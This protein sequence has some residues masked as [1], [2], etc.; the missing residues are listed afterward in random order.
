[1]SQRTKKIGELEALEKINYQNFTFC[2]Y[3]VIMY[4][5]YGSKTVVIHIYFEF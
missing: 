4:H 3:S 1:M 2:F 5:V